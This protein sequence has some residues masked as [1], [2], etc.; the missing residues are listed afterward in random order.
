MH[1]AS[2]CRPF[3]DP[4]PPREYQTWRS[5]P[6]QPLRSP[7]NPRTAAF[8]LLAF[9]SAAALAESPYAPY[10]NGPSTDDKHF[11]IAVWLQEPANA[12]RYKAIGINTYVALWK[13]PTEAQLTALE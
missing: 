3:A 8:L 2:R 13:G 7:M 5:P 1:F 4:N 12:A 10:K 11:P 9:W 6:P